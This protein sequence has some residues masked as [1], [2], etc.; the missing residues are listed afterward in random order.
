MQ[1][2]RHSAFKSVEAHRH[3][4]SYVHNALPSLCRFAYHMNQAKWP[5]LGLLVR[6]QPR[7]CL[8]RYVI[9]R[10]DRARIPVRCN[11]VFSMP[12][13]MPLSIAPW[14]CSLYWIRVDLASH[15]RFNAPITFVRFHR[16][17]PTKRGLIFL[18]GVFAQKSVDRTVEGRDCTSC[19]RQRCMHT[20]FCLCVRRSLPKEACFIGTIE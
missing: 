10:L 5:R 12:L 13:T 6:K 8:L 7:L 3:L 20:L 11:A 16:C 19:F 17:W 2:I 1:T 14:P 15:R 4:H 9:T 18:R